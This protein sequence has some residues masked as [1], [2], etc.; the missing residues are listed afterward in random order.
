MGKG[1]QLQQ[2]NSQPKH[3]PDDAA[4]LSS[5]SSDAED[6]SSNTANIKKD[7][8]SVRHESPVQVELESEDSVTCQWEDCGILF[9]HLPTLIDHIH[10]GELNFSLKI[11]RSFANELWYSCRAEHIGVHKSNYTC[12]WSSCLR[13]GLPQT[14]RFALIS[15]IRSHTGEKPFICPLPGDYPDVIFGCTSEP[16]R[17]KNATNLSHVQMPWPSI[18]ASNI[19]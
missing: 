17:S 9:T 3:L 6:A 16:W 18:C 13:R 12:E 7:Q 1:R 10:N 19:I 8:V 4:P 14:S 2:K 11:I 5:D 15:H